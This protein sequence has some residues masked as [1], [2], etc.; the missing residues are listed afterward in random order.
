MILEPGW[1]S[2]ADSFQ[3]PIEYLGKSKNILKFA[4]SEYS[5]DLA[6]PSFFREFTVDLDEGKTVAFKG[7]VWEVIEATNAALTYKVVRYFPS[8]T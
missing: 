6:R 2:A 8:R 1:F 5:D 7:A 3:Q 4:Y